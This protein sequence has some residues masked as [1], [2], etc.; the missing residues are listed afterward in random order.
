MKLFDFVCLTI[1]ALMM[2]A[3]VFLAYDFLPQ[4]STGSLFF[5]NFAM[6]LLAAGLFIGGGCLW[7][8]IRGKDK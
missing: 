6:Q 2:I 8:W 3:G 4:L 5:E 7:Q 1:A